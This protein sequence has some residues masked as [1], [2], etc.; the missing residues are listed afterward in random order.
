MVH[1]LHPGRGQVRLKL[2]MGCRRAP[3]GLERGA[4]S[5]REQPGSRDRGHRA[6]WGGRDAVKGLRAVVGQVWQGTRRGLGD[7]EKCCKVLSESA[8]LD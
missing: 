5:G 7:K 8:L 4:V 1:R 6:L 3:G 2:W